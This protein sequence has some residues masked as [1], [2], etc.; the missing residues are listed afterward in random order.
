VGTKTLKLIG[1]NIMSNEN[2]IV[3]SE[4]K[5]G[6]L[7]PVVTVQNALMAYQAKKDLIDGIM[8]EG[9]DYGKIPGTDKNTL[10]KAGAEKAISFFGLSTRFR[11]DVAI[12]DFN[13]KDHNG[14]T[15]FFYRRTCE[16]WR[17]D[18]FI[19]SASGS[20]NSWEKKYRYRWMDESKV[21]A[22]L[23]KATLKTQGGKISEPAFAIEKGE[24]TGK[25]GKPAEYW[26]RFRDEIA[27]GTATF[28]KRKT[29]AGADM[30]AYEIDGTLYCVPNEDPADV[31]NTVLK[32]SDKR[33]L[34]AVTL[35][36]TGLSEN[37]TQDMEDFISGDFVEITKPTAAPTPKTIYPENVNQETGEVTDPLELI[38][39]MGEWAMKF[40]CDTWNCTP[41]EAA[42]RITAMKLGKKVE[43]ADFIKIVTG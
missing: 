37:F 9:V 25:Y 10:L 30:D 42:P 28:T 8:R 23:D 34:V 21:P 3:V 17:G 16:L 32:I 40:A 13:G 39:P 18:Y 31:A 4:S 2:E 19:A 38:V 33:A 5:A 41:A 27:N 36:A 26:Q 15:F 6:F 11:D 14:E 12:E 35:I 43:K 22:N 7:A 24:T 20:C 29:R 1:E